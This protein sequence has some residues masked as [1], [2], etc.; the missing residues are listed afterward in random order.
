M[1]STESIKRK[2]AEATDAEFVRFVEQIETEN[3]V[4]TAALNRDILLRIL[5][6]LLPKLE[7]T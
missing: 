3:T 6:R 5:K 1:S 7:R 4:E 2:L